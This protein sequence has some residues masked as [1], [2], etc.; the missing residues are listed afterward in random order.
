MYSYQ[1][2]ARHCWSNSFIDALAC[3]V[4]FLLFTWL[5]LA[6]WYVAIGVQVPFSGPSLVSLC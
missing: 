1:A 3:D 4:G 2:D 5:A 6:E